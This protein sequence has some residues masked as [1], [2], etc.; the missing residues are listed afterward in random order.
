MSDFSSKIKELSRKISSWLSEDTL[1]TSVALQ[2]PGKY[3]VLSGGKRV[4]GVLTLLAGELLHI[5]HSRLRPLAVSLELIHAA[6]LVHDDLPA[7]DNDELRRGKPSS[8]VQY[9]EDIAVVTGDALIADGF[10]VVANA[11]V[12]SE[13][14]RGRLVGLLSKTVVE[15]CD[16]QA[17]DLKAG[18]DVESEDELQRRHRLKTGALIAAAASAP[19]LLDGEHERK[20]CFNHLKLFGLSLGLLFQV[21]DDLLDVTGSAEELGKE[22]LADQRQETATYVSVLGMEQAQQRADQIL[23]EAKA[24]LAVLEGDTWELSAISDYVRDRDR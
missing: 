19:A 13:A 15:L 24:Q 3:S 11:N 22:P 4:R 20:L 14:E 10:N 21:T 8:H 1:A 2:E 16:G 6:S 12:L 7:L 23:A 5:D 9:G 17:L 18:T